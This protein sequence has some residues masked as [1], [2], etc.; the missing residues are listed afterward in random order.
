MSEKSS[1]KIWIVFLK[2]SGIGDSAI[3]VVTVFCIEVYQRL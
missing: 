1:L 2:V 3:E